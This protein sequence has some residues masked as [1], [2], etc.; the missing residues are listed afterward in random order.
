MHHMILFEF[1][2]KDRGTD[3]RRISEEENIKRTTIY[4]LHRMQSYRLPVK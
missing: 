2:L 4:G 1:N 3:L